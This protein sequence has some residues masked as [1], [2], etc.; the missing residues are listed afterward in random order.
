MNLPRYFRV[1]YYSKFNLSDAK[2]IALFFGGKVISKNITSVS[3]KIIWKC[4]D[5]HRFL[6]APLRM[7]VKNNFCNKCSS[8]Y[9]GEEIARSIMEKLTKKEFPKIRH[10]KILS[11]LGNPMEID[12]YN[13]ELK[14]GFEHQG[15]HHFEKESYVG[16]K[17]GF[18]TKT[19]DLSKLNQSKKIGIKLIIFPEIPTYLNVAGAI[20]LAT[21]ELSKFNLI[22]SKITPKDI[23]PVQNS[24]KI[25]E[26]K[27]L[28]NKFK[29][30]LLSKNYLGMH[31]DYYWI[32]ENKHKFKSK[33]YNVKTGWWCRKCSQISYDFND[34]IKFA[35]KKKGKCLSKKYYNVHK[36]YKWTCIKQHIWLATWHAIKSGIWCLKCK[37]GAKYTINELKQFAI[38]KKGRLLSKKYI[39]T[40]TVYKWK[41]EQGH[42][43]NAAWHSIRRGTWCRFCAHIITAQKNRKS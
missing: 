10:K 16:K 8:F 35:D 22:L 38:K 29:G 34:L 40:H 19:K 27:K 1:K 17:W 15:K 12:G 39:S 7:K 24:S 9:L 25:E 21:E 5:G 36:K 31:H 26:L 13:D 11:D 37:G 33:A 4:K 32:C 28:A 41:C 2:E 6:R 18:N 43:W 42:I 14:I 3:Q 23:L 20:K 30:Q